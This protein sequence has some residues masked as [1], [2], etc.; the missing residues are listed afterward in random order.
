MFLVGFEGFDLLEFSHNYDMVNDGEIF[1]IRGATLG[2]IPG[3]QVQGV[4]LLYRFDGGAGSAGAQIIKML[5][6]WHEFIVSFRAG[7]QK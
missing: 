6:S 5:V 1:R 7:F 3:Q 2:K 4:R